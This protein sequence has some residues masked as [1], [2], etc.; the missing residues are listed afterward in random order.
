MACGAQGR[1]PDKHAPSF[2]Y[3]SLPEQ[4]R[5]HCR[6]GE[7]APIA[8]IPECT[9]CPKIGNVVL[10]AYKQLPLIDLCFGALEVGRLLAKGSPV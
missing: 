2:T 9:E 3:L 7:C 1:R 10:V 6:D 5:F 4:Q 8:L